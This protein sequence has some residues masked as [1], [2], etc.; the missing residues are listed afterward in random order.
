MSS[1]NRGRDRNKY[2]Y[3]ITPQIEIK[4]FFE[5][6]KNYYINEDSLILD[7][8]AGGDINHEMS[9]P[10][11]LKEYGYK[12]DT[13]D[14]REDSRAEIIADYLNYEVTKKY[15]IIITNPPFN[16]S[17]DFLK[18]ALDD[19]E[20]GGYVIMLLRLNFYGSK[21]RND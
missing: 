11:V 18:K 17:M 13:L 9:Y 12:V 16:L 7:P 4:K 21:K 3:Y 5:I 1:T 8:C 19:V 20:D 6:F 15:D 10:S 14:I 2:D